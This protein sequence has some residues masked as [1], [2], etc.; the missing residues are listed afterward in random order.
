MNVRVKICGITRPEDA[1]AACEAGADA[2]GFIF[3]PKSPRY[4]PPEDARR[5]AQKLPPF[6]SRVGVF[7]NAPAEEVRRAAQKVGLSAVQLHGDEAPEYCAEIQ[8][9]VVKAFRVLDSAD[10]PY[11]A[12]QNAGA[13]AFL[14][15][16]YDPTRRG[17]TGKTFRWELAREAARRRPVILAGGLR[18]GNAAEAARAVQPYALDVSSGVESSPGVKDH[19][20]VRAFLRIVK[21]FNV[22]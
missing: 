14:L 13:A 1:L 12:Y 6:V 7:V 9:P 11:A 8:T 19:G 16:A 18:P 20:K 10:F 21:T 3:Y 5:I 4:I 17:G 22:V 15:D 2:L